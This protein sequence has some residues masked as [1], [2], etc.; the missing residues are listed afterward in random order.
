MNKSCVKCADSKLRCNLDQSGSP[1]SRC[2]HKGW[3]CERAERKKRARRATP[4]QTSSIPSPP[5]TGSDSR[6]DTSLDVSPALD[7]P[8]DWLSPGLL[9][10]GDLDFL[11]QLAD[12]ESFDTF[13]DMTTWDW[14]PPETPFP[15][16]PTAFGE[17][18][19]ATTTTAHTDQFLHQPPRPGTPLHDTG[20]II[21]PDNFRLPADF[22]LETEPADRITIPVHRLETYARLFFAHFHPLFPLLHLPTFHLASAPP[23]L[24]RTITSI[25]AAFNPTDPTSLNDAKRLY[26]SL[27]THFAKTCL[28]SPDHPTQPSLADLQ[29]L[30]LSQFAS[31]AKGGS[32]E[33]AAAR[34]LHPL[35]VTAVR[36]QGLLKVH[37]EC[38][39][40]AR[41]ARAWEAWVAKESRK[42][43]LWGVYAVDCY[44]ALLGG[45]KPLLSPQETRASFPCDEA[46]WGAWSASGWAALPAQDP[47]SCFQS[48]VRG[49]M[50]AAAAAV[51]GGGLE[52]AG[53]SSKLTAW[54]LNLLILAIHSLLLEA[55][56][57]ILPVDLSAMERALHTWKAWWD[58]VS[59][60]GAQRQQHHV[61]RAG[62]LLITNS[63][64]LYHL[65]VY[66]LKHGRPE[67]DES[68]YL[69]RST[70]PGNPLIKREEVF[71]ETMTRWVQN[72]MEELQRGEMADV[73]EL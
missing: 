41:N 24:I 73:D 68:A 7:P 47:S 67:L 20:P 70:N 28:R 39:V 64:T 61:I 14:T 35:L 42:R 55:Q 62:G 59:R 18:P 43:V 36:Q 51:R 53:A 63:V 45:S 27:P 72:M 54:D 17:P 11:N 60:E 8:V 21:S 25:G 4:R 37:G 22:T 66:L 15:D 3:H 38:T 46:S 6:W 2:R 30:L 33:R 26:S 1:C 58:G 49:L 40:A 13:G 52:A 16:N 48:A 19:R 65:A 32:A 56:T 50:G 29:A 69:G 44:Q 57:S 12:I 31:T 23:I 9:S 5:P 71:Q 10:T 34:L